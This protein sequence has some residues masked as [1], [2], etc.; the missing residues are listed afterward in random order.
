MSDVPWTQL[1]A[2]AGGTGLVVYLL[3]KVTIP[4]MMKT[5]KESIESIVEAHQMD[6]EADRKAHKENT[7]L[8][9]GAIDRIPCIGPSRGPVSC[10]TTD[11]LP[12]V[13]K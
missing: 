7:K 3:L 10:D 1:A 6:R 11:T 8:I 5:F 9:T 13:G 2:G 12:K 4:A